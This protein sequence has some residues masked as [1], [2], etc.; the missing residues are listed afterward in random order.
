MALAHNPKIVTDGL[1]LCLDAANPK[2]YPGSGTVWK[3]LSGNS[4]DGTLVNGV[5]FDGDNKGSLT[6]DGVNDTVNVVG[7]ANRYFP[8]L[9]FT[10]ECAFKNTQTT[11]NGLFSLSF[12]LILRHSSSSGTFQVRLDNGT[13][14]PSFSP[15]I[16]SPPVND[17]NWYITSVVVNGGNNATIDFY[18]NGLHYGQRN[19][20]WSGSTR[21][22]TNSVGLG[23][24]NNDPS[25]SRYNGNIS[26]L[27]I[28]NRALSAEEISQNFQALRGR[29][30]I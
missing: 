3:D 20:S 26:L 15:P 19:T 28:Y 27:K 29:Y 24:D 13:S 30:G 6:F 9:N 12:G 22:P 2:S 10:L 14:V 16:S 1:V 4:N 5:G 21:W 17:G 8:I 25:A 11:R 18:I 7:P 23:R